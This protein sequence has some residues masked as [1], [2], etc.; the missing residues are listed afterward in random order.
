[1]SMST[2][3]TGEIVKVGG[4]PSIKKVKP[5]V[6]IEEY[7]VGRTIGQGAYGKVMLAKEIATGREVAIKSVS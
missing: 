6:S 1:M 2:A 7:D 5:K 4:Q 3:M